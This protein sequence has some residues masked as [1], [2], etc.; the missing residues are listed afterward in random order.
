MSSFEHGGLVVGVATWPN[1]ARSPVCLVVDDLT[2]GWIDR[3]GSGRALGG[4]DWGHG[5]DGPG[6]AFHLFRLGLLDVFPEARATFFVPVD[7]LEDIRPATYTPHFLRIDRRPEFGEF[8]R[9]LHGD[10]RFEC[11]Y[12]G[13]YHGIPGPTGAAYVPE[14]EKEASLDEACR[15]IDAGKAIWRS[16]FGEDPVGGKFP[17]FAWGP[18]GEQA[19]AQSGFRWWSRRWDRE[20]AGFRDPVGLTPRYFGEPA[21]VD[22][23]STLHGG[24]LSEPPLRSVGVHHIPGA[25]RYRIWLRR[26][27]WL[28]LGDLLEARAPITIQEHMNRSRTDE[29]YQRPNVL[30]DIATLRDIYRRL[31]RHDVWHATCGE[32]ASYFEARSLVHL[33]VVSADAF[34]VS[35]AD[36]RSRETPLSLCLN[37][38]QLPD[39]FQLTNGSA[40]VLVPVARRAGRHTCV[41]APIP[42]PAGRYAIGRAEPVVA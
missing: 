30:D 7:R 33:R 3:D 19:V 26:Q 38:P 35:Y 41:T 18:A 40:S 29:R 5:L 34:V 21:V 25:L 16:V 24:E 36:G 31:Q 2:D 4:N 13:S 8:L 20:L 39:V 12:H 14:F 15:A 42:L 17:A 23:P 37:G 11:A 32:I 28:Q 27:F 6:S 22:I 10:E 9:T 1:D